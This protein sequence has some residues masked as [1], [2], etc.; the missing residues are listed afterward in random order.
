MNEDTRKL[1]EAQPAYW[2]GYIRGR[3][4]LAQAALGHGAVQR[5]F[6]YMEDALEAIGSLSDG[7]ESTVSEVMCEEAT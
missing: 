4:V 3:I 2:A 6:E 5:A 7:P 1:I